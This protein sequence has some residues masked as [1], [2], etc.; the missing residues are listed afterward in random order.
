L[1]KRI[2][3]IKNPVRKDFTRARLQTISLQEINYEG[4]MFVKIPEIIK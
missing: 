2:P 3:G 4:H 1:L